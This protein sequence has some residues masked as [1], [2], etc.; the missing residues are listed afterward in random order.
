MRVSRMARPMSRCRS[1]TTSPSS[2]SSGASAG[3]SSMSCGG[4]SSVTMA[5]PR[6]GAGSRLRRRPHSDI[7]FRQASRSIGGRS[8]DTPVPFDLD[9][10]VRSHGFYDLPPWTYDPE[11]RVLARPLRLATGRTAR[12]EV[13]QARAAGAGPEDGAAH[14][15]GLALRVLAEGRLTAAEGREVRAQVR[16][17]LALDED[18]GP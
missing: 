1:M 7:P 8:L 12:V 14:G 13:A 9:L 16:T 11:R 6:L 2:P 15:E 3:D 4:I 5:S 18:L 17:C 10:T